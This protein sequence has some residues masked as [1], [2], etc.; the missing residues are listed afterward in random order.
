MNPQKPKGVSQEEFDKLLEQIDAVSSNEDSEDYEDEDLEEDSLS[1]SKNTEQLDSDDSVEEE[2]KEK[3]PKNPK[4]K[5]SVHFPKE[6]EAGP[7][8][9]LSS[10]EEKPKPI[11]RNKSEKTPV[12]EEAIKA[13]SDVE[14]PRTI[15]PQTDAFK[16]VF[17]ERNTHVLD[18]STSTT[19]ETVEQPKKPVSRFKAQRMGTK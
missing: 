4:R 11:L 8:P 3:S 5:R 10:R 6:L 18:P 1:D 13:M 2:P 17:V 15:L 7:S 14:R 12:N 16:G 9:S 19:M